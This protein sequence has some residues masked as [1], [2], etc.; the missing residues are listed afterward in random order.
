MFGGL[1]GAA[2]FAA[3][4][5]GSFNQSMHQSQELQLER[6]RLQMQQQRDLMSRADKVR[7]E[8]W[9]R[10]GETVAAMRPDHD[11]A[12]I[13]N[14]IKPFI[15]P[16]ERITASSGQDPKM[17]GLQ[18]GLMLNRP[19]AYDIAFGKQKQKLEEF[20]QAQ[21]AGVFNQSDAFEAGGAAP[22]PFVGQDQAGNGL[23][24]PQGDMPPAPSVP[25]DQP[26]EDQEFKA[27]K[28]E[29]L[30]RAEDQAR[31]DKQP[32]LADQF[33]QE[34]RKLMKESAGGHVDVK[35]S[36]DGSYIFIHKDTGQI[37]DENGKIY[38]S[39]KKDATT[40]IYE[41]SSPEGFIGALSGG[42]NGQDA[43]IV[44][45]LANYTI[46]PGSLPNR[47]LK[48]EGAT[49]RQKYT[50]LASRYAQLRGETY[51][52]R[53]YPAR[54]RALAT[55]DSPTPASN[56]VRSFNVVVDHLGILDDT[57][58]ALKN[59]DTAALNALSNYFKTEFGLDAAPNTFE[60]IKSIVADELTKAVLGSAG[61]L[62]DREAL[63]KGLDKSKSPKLLRD[64]IAHYE[65]LAGGQLSG[66]RK[67]YEA[68]T[69]LKNFDQ[70]FLFPHTLQVMNSG[71]KSKEEE[72]EK[73]GEWEIEE[74]K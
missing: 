13:M 68:G 31:R 29:R 11:Q 52:Q 41:Q 23:L 35:Q 28:I 49:Q 44:K 53:E 54:K 60:G 16:L 22:T 3:G 1:A 9:D 48:G 27:Q 67:Q 18:I 74:I 43:Q 19:N 39:P 7:S 47:Q 51:D 26:Q 15:A 57:I 10:L 5:G 36:P 20:K 2:G 64:L 33:R 72:P 65:M 25:Q 58:D 14:A 73:K 8:M 50:A 55:W 61:A 37:L 40:S 56:A 12:S 38:H 59:K 4:F 42:D 66:L 63:Q 69:G 45:G 30:I 32:A 21:A 6:Q 24:T 34:R 71:R 17:V 46:D 70:K 62:G